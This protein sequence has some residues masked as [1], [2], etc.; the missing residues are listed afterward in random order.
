MNSKPI[1]EKLVN[2]FKL[3]YG[4][5]M[6]SLIDER[7]NNLVDIIFY[8]NHS[9]SKELGTIQE[10]LDEYNIDKYRDEIIN[11]AIPISKYTLETG[12]QGT[13]IYEKDGIL[14]MVI[15]FPN[16]TSKQFNYDCIL[17]H[18][19][20]HVLDEHITYNDSNNIISQGGFET[21][22]LKG[23]KQIERSY[24]FLNEIIHQ[25]IAEEI[26]EYLYNKDIMIVNTKE[27]KKES[28][29]YYK[30]D[31][32]EVIEYFYNSFKSK[33]L[34]DKLIGNIDEFINYIGKDNFEDFN[35]WIKEFYNTY[36]TPEDRL[37]K[38]NSKEYIDITNKGLS[39]VENMVKK[40][41]EI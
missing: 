8:N 7:I 16:T 15:Y 20:L 13:M 30:K 21:T 2:C 38:K 35:N 27:E 24:E 17:I 25:R 33:L 18:E 34:T 23:D 6:S 36:V 12:Q 31:R 10:Y 4:E 37:N 39:V 32:S 26:N 19:L 3:F 11:K 5:S 1:I 41:R 40:T 14:R 29:E 28:I 22:V 9:S